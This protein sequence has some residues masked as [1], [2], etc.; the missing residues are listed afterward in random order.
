MRFERRSALLVFACGIAATIVSVGWWW[1]IFS[2][3]T[4]NDYLTYTQAAT[5]LAGATDLCNLAQALCTDQHLYG[6]RWYAPEAFWA[7]SAVLLAGL[8]MISRPSP[9]SAR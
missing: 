8:L 4:D 1:L 7:G 5:C 2:R 6:I 9:V 3:V